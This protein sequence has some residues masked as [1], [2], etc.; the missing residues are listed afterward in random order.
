M[1]KVQVNF[2]KLRYP[3]PIT[4]TGAMVE[5]KPNYLTIGYFAILSHV[6]AIVSISLYKDH[7]TIAGIKQN[8]AFSVNIPSVDMVKVTDYCGIVSGKDMDKSRLFESFY[9]QLNTAPMIKECP[10]NFECKLVQTIQAG[11]N[12]LFIGEVVATYANEEVLT[13]GVPDIL[14]VAPLVLFSVDYHSWQFG[15]RV[16]G[17]Y[18][19]GRELKKKKD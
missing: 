15:P 13:D 1:G 8:G 17:A 10:L 6:P 7:Y 16:A 2:M 9:G 11:N 14:K 3:L 4:L 19:V 18:S 5:G 12:F